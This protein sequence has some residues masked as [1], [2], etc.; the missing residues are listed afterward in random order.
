MQRTHNPQVAC[1]G[2]ACNLHAITNRVM[3][4]VAG[5]HRFAVPSGRTRRKCRRIGSV[6]RRLT[7]QS[8]SAIGV[9]ADADAAAKIGTHRTY[10][11]IH[12]SGYTE[13][14][15]A[16]CALQRRC[17][18]QSRPSP[19]CAYAAVQC[20]AVL[21]SAVQCDAA[22]D[23]LARRRRLHRVPL[24]PC[25]MHAH[26]ATPLGMRATCLQEGRQPHALRL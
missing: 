14:E 19:I 6:Y 2:P 3:C 22:S 10:V 24:Q 8:V 13:G 7:D 20:C 16:Y 12:L 21:C 5:C 11:L 15:S 9:S 18:E 4:C 1:D 25:C 23:G 26:L 17:A